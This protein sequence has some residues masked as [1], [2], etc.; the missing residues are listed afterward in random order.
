MADTRERD[1]AGNLVTNQIGSQ[2]WMDAGFTGIEPSLEVK[3]AFSTAEYASGWIGNYAQ[4][5]SA[6]G[7]PVSSAVSKIAEY[8][9]ASSPVLAALWEDYYAISPQAAY[10][11]RSGQAAAALVANQAKTPVVT[12]ANAA[13]EK[14]TLN[15]DT[16]LND[17]K[18]P[19][20]SIASTL[21]SYAMY[22]IIGVVVIV[23][24]AVVVAK[25]HVGGAA[26]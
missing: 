1:A 22:I 11:Q 18:N 26:A 2:Y 21:G 25:T 19:V 4:I 6:Q 23:L 9:A 14:G 10:D 12:P 13:I 20:N 5:L 8:P 16:S 15:T 7:T 17:G 24:A 3:A